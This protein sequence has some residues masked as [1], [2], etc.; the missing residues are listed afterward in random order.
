MDTSTAG[1][2]GAYGTVPPA[3]EALAKFVK[4]HPTDPTGVPREEMIRAL[5]GSFNPQQVNQ[6][7]D[8]L[9]QEGHL[10]STIDDQHFSWCGS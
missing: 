6:A 7:I 5:T 1:V 8:Y 9:H 3:S 4:A 10:Y 2:F